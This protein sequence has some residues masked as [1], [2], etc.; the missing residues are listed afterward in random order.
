MEN[1]KY[2]EDAARFA[3]LTDDEI[4]DLLKTRCGVLEYITNG[5][6]KEMPKTKKKF[7]NSWILQLPNICLHVW[8]D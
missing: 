2:E 7:Q 6:L 1:A 4:N 8:Q 3:C 5:E